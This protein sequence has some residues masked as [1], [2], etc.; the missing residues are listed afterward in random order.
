[1]NKKALT[2]Q[3]ILQPFQQQIGSIFLQR[4]SAGTFICNYDAEHFIFKMEL[5]AIKGHSM[6]LMRK[7]FQLSISRAIVLLFLKRYWMGGLPITH[8]FA[9]LTKNHVNLKAFLI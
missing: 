4:I 8:V 3:F 1:V 2:G 9:S 6:L 5:I 7:K